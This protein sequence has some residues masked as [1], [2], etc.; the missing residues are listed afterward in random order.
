MSLHEQSVGA[1]SEWYTPAYVFEAM[2]QTFDMD[3]ASP[4]A[5]ITPWIPAKR[6][7]VSDS[8]QLPWVGFVW[9]NPPFGGRNAIAT[10]LAKFM[11]HGNGIALTPGR[12]SCPWWQTYSRQAAEV[13]LV[14]AKTR[15]IG[16]GGKPGT[17]PAQGTTLFAKGPRA[18]EALK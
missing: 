3:A 2:A 17:S 12:S 14:N 11:D 16:Q 10:W 7:L 4:G 13:L 5:H 6:F 8:L 1:T 9:M 18:V 15:F